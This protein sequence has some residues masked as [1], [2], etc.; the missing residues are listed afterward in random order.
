MSRSTGSPG[1]YAKPHVVE[2]RCPRARP[3]SATAPGPVDHLGARVEQL[4]DALRAGQALLDGVVR[5]HQLLERLVEQEACAVRKADEACPACAVPA[6]TLR[7]PYQTMPAT[8]KPASTSVIGQRADPAAAHEEAED[9]LV[10]LVEARRLRIPPAERLDDAVALHVLV[11]HRVQPRRRL[12]LAAAV[13]PQL[14]REQ[15]QRQPGEREDDEWRSAPAPSP[16]RRRPTTSPMSVVVSWKT[17]RDR[18]GDASCAPGSRRP[19]RATRSGRR[20][21]G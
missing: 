8:A 12:L 6:M 1:S 4:E 13:L 3:R 9:A 2:A 10:L 18:V 14:L 21:G 15:A 17:E 16:C 7:P 19:S 20:A 5:P 11:Q